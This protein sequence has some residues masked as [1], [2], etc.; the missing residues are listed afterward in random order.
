MPSRLLTA[1]CIAGL[2]SAATSANAVADTP[3][4][5]TTRPTPIRAWD[6]VAAF[7]L[8]DSAS[9]GYRLAI[10]HNGGP[11]EVL[12]VAAQPTAFDVDVGRNRSGSPAIVYSRCAST[13]RRPRGCDLYR[14]SLSAGSE[15]KLA[16]ASS[17]NASE[18]SPTIW[19]TRVAWARLSDGRE[20]PGAADLHAHAERPAVASFAKA[21]GYPVPPVRQRRLHRQRTRAPRAVAGNECRVSRT[22]VQ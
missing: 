19:D 22:G 1:L 7:S 18:T 14:Y 11:P 4:G 9:G 12:A 10:S 16:G 13:G 8:Y 17:P 2:G 21:G 3:I 6:G 20:S 5:T 15:S